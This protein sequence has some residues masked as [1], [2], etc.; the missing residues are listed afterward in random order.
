VVEDGFGLLGD[1]FVRSPGSM[2][3]RND[4]PVAQR[5]DPTWLDAEPRLAED[6]AGAK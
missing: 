3:S 1:N 6:E 4:R 5:I 2:T